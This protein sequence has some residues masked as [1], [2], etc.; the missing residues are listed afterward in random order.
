MKNRPKSSHAC[1]NSESSVIR[2]DGPSGFAPV[3]RRTSA[4]A[5][6]VNLLFKSSTV[7]PPSPK[8]IFAKPQIM[9][10][11]GTCRMLYFRIKLDR[12]KPPKMSSSA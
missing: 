11:V 2:G 12:P 5:S 1:E 7:R 9:R 8:F 10:N 4:T 3:G 6:H